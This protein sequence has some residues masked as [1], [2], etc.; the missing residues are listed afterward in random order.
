MS[1][2]RTA[3]SFRPPDGLPVESGVLVPDIMGSPLSPIAS[4]TVVQHIS[5]AHSRNE[6]IPPR[7]APGERQAEDNA[8][9]RPR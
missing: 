6:T 2:W 5:E 9:G 8:A 4:P 7:V 3:I 1:A